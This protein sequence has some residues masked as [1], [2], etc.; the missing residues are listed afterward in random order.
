MNVTARRMLH[1][2]VNKGDYV[3]II[4]STAW[5]YIGSPMLMPT[6]DHILCFIRIPTM[7]L[8]ILPQLPITLAGKTVC[9][10]VMVV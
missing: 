7:P 9:I 4:S 8:D 1:T 2:I 5:K 6:T 3:S 10:D